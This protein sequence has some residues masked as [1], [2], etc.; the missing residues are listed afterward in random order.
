MNRFYNIPADEKADILRGAGEKMNLP[1]YAVE[2]DWWSFRPCLFFL[3]WKLGSIWY[4][5][6]ALL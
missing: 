1:A 6:V 3:K 2:K 5:K 4:L